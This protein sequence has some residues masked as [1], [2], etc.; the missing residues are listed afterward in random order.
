MAAVIGADSR[1]RD[2]AGVQR[3]LAGC[4]RVVVGDLDERGA[5]DLVG[6]APR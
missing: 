1:L 2:F 3:D 6:D 5:G 4:D